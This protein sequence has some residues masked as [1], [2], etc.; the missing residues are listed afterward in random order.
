MNKTLLITRIDPQVEADKKRQIFF[1]IGN[2]N[3]IHIENKML[4]ILTTSSMID[5]EN[6]VVR[7]NGIQLYLYIRDIPKVIK[8]LVDADIDIYSVYEIYHP[9]I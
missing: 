2:L 3:Q 8:L 4:D 7:Y 6:I 5:R 1:N 9:N